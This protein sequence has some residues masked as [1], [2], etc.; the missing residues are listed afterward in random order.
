MNAWPIHPKL[1]VWAL[2]LLEVWLLV[3]IQL[4]REWKWNP[5]Y[6]FGFI[7]P[8]LGLYLVKDRIGNIRFS[9]SV[10]SVKWSAL[11]ILLPLSCFLI[12]GEMLRQHDPLWRF[13]SFTTV[14]GASVFTLTAGGVIFGRSWPVLFLPFFVLMMT[15]VPWPNTIEEQV[16]NQLLSW[17]VLNTVFLLNLGG[18]AASQIGNAIQISTGVVGI[19]NAC[20][21]IQSLQAGLMASIFLT[22][23]FRLGLKKSIFL[24]VTVLALA[25]GFNFLRTLALVVITHHHPDNGLERFHDSIGLTITVLLFLSSA[26]IAWKMSDKKAAEPVGIDL[27]VKRFLPIPL[28]APF[29]LLPILAWLGLLY[30]TQNVQTR[31]TETP[32]WI[33]QTALLPAGWKARPLPFDPVEK[34]KLRWDSAEG[35]QV[36]SADG[37]KVEVFHFYWGKNNK[38]PSSAFIHPPEVCMPSQG[39]KEFRPAH[40]MTLNIHGK[41]IKGRLLFFEQFGRRETLFHAM[42]R[43]AIVFSPSEVHRLKLLWKAPRQYLHEELFLHLPFLGTE[44]AQV[45]LAEKVLGALMPSASK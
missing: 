20:S 2:A 25:V 44:A 23:F 4:S 19:D 33:L 1:L 39:W 28:A 13:T 29:L 17:V 7:V 8:F 42:D 16:T 26:L 35:Y 11:A 37:L 41:T 40:P 38:L 27:Q 5:Q 3:F 31:K 15:A 6:Q 10:P 30:L 18:V 12:F 45:E 9:E 14:I 22:F 24:L 32:E 21:G 34:S 43:D 36:Q